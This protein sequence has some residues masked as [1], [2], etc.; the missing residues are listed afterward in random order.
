MELEARPDRPLENFV[1]TEVHL[2]LSQSGSI[3]K[4]SVTVTVK[5]ERREVL[6]VA[7]DVHP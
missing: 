4:V 5:S 3:Q 6:T 2:L 7:E 1:K